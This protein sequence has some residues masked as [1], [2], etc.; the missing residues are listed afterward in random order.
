MD[1]YKLPITVSLLVV[2]GLLTTAII[3]SLLRARRLPG[4]PSGPIETGPLEAEG[5]R[6]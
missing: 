5:R 4:E 3:V 1:I 2:A 6:G